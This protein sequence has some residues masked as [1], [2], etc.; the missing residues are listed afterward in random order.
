MPFKLSDKETDRNYYKGEHVVY[1]PID[2]SSRSAVGQIQDVLTE[3]TPIGSA[4][5]RLGHITIHASEDEPRYVIR[6]LNT[7]KDTAYKRYN[8]MRD[9]TEEEVEKK[10]SEFNLDKDT[11][12]HVEPPHHGVP[13]A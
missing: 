1:I 5:P 8:I 6:N 7:D 12:P 10:N 3:E 2:H 11:S 13:I 4:S 9:A